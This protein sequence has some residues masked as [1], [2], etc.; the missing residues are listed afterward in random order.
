MFFNKTKQ[1]D[2]KKYSDINKKIID[3]TAKH[4]GKELTNKEHKVLRNM[5]NK[6]ANALSK[7]SG[8]PVYSISKKK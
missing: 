1:K 2:A 3:F 5:L 4:K 7:I 6:R 8:S